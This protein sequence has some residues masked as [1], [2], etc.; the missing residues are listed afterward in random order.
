[1][2]VDEPDANAP[3]RLEV[4]HLGRRGTFQD[5]SLQ[6]RAGDVVGIAGLVGSGRT[7]VLRAIFG[8]DQPDTGEILVDGA[9][10]RFSSPAQAVRRGL[11]LLPEDRKT[12]GLLLNRALRENVALSSLARFSRFGVLSLRRE[13]RVIRG[14]MANLQIAARGPGQL[15]ATLQRRQPAKGGACP[16]ARS[17]VS[18]PP[19]RRAD[20]RGRYWC[21]GRDLP[22]NPGSGAVRERRCWSSPPNSKNYSRCARASS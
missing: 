12:Q 13:E 10:V 19:L 6:L 18:H 5:V 14:L 15:A 22:A 1:M 8:A 17:T 20:T 21:Q 7:E 9:R 11:G 3:L 2:T 4:R 16:L